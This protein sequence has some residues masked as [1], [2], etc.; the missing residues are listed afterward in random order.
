M[1]I[2]FL[3]ALLA[4]CVASAPLAAQESLLWKFKPGEKFHYTRTQ[5]TTK[6]TTAGGVTT[7]EST[8]RAADMT[9]AV[10]QVAADGTAQITQTVDRVRYRRES[11][12]GVVE[13][14][15]ASAGAP[16]GA[17]VRVAANLKELLDSE[18]TFRVTPHGETRDIRVLARA[19]AGVNS[20]ARTAS[21]LTADGIKSLLPF[22]ALPEGA[23]TPGTTWR[24]QSE[25][26]E[27]SLG[28]RKVD[29]AYKYAGPEPHGGRQLIKI[30]LESDIRFLPRKGAKVKMDL[31]SCRNAGTIFFDARAGRLEVRQETEKLKLALIEK[32]RILDQEVEITSG[33]K[34]NR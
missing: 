4:L 12:A 25:F 5:D 3:Q 9:V 17:A 16:K 23:V 10:N 15:S 24:E 6:N 27:P 14:D 30:T 7:K 26:A 20:P 1:S 13:Y 28:M 8:L 21:A 34:L 11:P 2:R 18:F 33:V 29:T 22:F 31:K 32:D 19:A